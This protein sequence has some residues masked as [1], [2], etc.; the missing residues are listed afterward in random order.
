MPVCP[1]CQ[2]AVPLAAPTCT[3][4]GHDFILGRRL[5]GWLPS[6][7]RIRRRNLMLGALSALLA[8]GVVVAIATLSPGAPPPAGVP[9]ERWLRALQ[10]SVAERLADGA[11]VPS[12]SN[13]VDADPQCWRSVGIDPSD[14]P[15]P[16]SARI[17]LLAEGAGFALECRADEDGDGEDALWR[18]NAMVTAVRVT[19][20]DVR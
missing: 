17:R 7:A 10:P 1:S 4:C 11:A 15:E 18:A 3:R 8:L 6:D 5:D 13:N 9:C 16:V 20:S 14:L 12:C 2:G 19:R